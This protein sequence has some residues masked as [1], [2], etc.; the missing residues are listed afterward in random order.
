[1][2]ICKKQL[3]TAIPFIIYGVISV[4]LYSGC[5][6]QF[7]YDHTVDPNAP[8]SVE[9]VR[10]S[11]L[12]GFEPDPA[13]GV[14]LKAHVELFDALDTQIQKPAVFRFELY[15]FRRLS[16]DPRGHRIKLWSDQDLTS[17]QSQST[18]WRDY[19]SGYEFFLPA[20]PDL[21]S[22]RKYVLD[23]TCMVDNKRHM[24]RLRFSYE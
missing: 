15:H 3:S 18:H 10:L 20:P 4:F 1:M 2:K 13:G 22:G 17:E 14:R 19:L 6:I 23:V 12:T 7:S 5:G 9:R 21:M 24:D 16:R 11:T 8:V